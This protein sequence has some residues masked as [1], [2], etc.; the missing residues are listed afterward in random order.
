M[1]LSTT[2][3]TM[4]AALTN[5]LPTAVAD[6]NSDHAGTVEFRILARD[7]VDGVTRQKG[8]QTSCGGDLAYPHLKPILTH[9]DVASA[10]MKKH[11]FAGMR[12]HTVTFQLT[13]EAKRKLAD[14]CSD[15]GAG[16]LGVFVEGNYAGSW[17]FRKAKIGRFAPMAGFLPSE[18]QAQRIVAA[19]AKD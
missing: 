3:L 1:F 16:E 7:A 15:A 18:D 13:A 2:L 12:Q 19:C 14:A 17:I 8:I 4:A 9:A 6:E 5:S 10:R 11:F